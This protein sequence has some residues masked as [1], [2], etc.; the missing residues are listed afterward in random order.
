MKVIAIKVLGSDKEPLIFELTPGMT[1][2]DLLAEADL[3]KYLLV[4][5]DDPNTYL[6]PGQDL[7]A[8]LED[9]EMLWATTPVCE[10][11]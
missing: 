2:S 7:D 1:T 9:C 10:V 4:R 3:A 6:S 5:K 8:I 11:Y